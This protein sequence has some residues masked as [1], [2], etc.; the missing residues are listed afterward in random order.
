MV[1]RGGRQ[2]VGQM[3]GGDQKWQ[4]SSFKI[5]HLDRIHSMMTIV[6]NTVLH[7]WKLLRISLK[8][9]YYN[10]IS[11]TMWGDELSVDLLWWSF[12]NIYKY[13]V[14]PRWC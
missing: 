8:N 10:K 4:T 6:N 2:L 9:S 11:V 1:S 7:I 13:K 14:L 5:I 3:N 12:H